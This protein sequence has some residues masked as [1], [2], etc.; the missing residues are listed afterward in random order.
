M[1][2]DLVPE[3][4]SGSYFP[5]Y[6]VYFSSEE[7]GEI[8]RN[9]DL[10]KEQGRMV[11]KPGKKEFGFFLDDVFYQIG[12]E[13]VRKKSILMDRK[14]EEHISFL[15]NGYGRVL[16]SRDFRLY[17]LFS[18]KEDEPVFETKDTFFFRCNEMV[19]YFREYMRKFR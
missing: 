8:A 16:M 5:L 3:I 11:G 4:Y 19:K 18:K 2:N 7:L 1:G 15:K 17:H 13:I 10:I 9:Y 14:M 6:G 12:E